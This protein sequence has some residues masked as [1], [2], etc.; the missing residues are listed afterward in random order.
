MKDTRLVEMRVFRAVAEAGG[1]TAAART[2]GVSQSFVSQTVSDLERRLGVAL[3]HRSTRAHRLTPE[4]ENYLAAAR[5]LL[6]AIDVAEGELRPDEPAGVLRV[7]A[8]RAFGADQVV[9]RMPEFLSRH[10]RVSLRLSLSDQMASLLEDGFDVAIRMGRLQDPS[11]ASRPLARLQR[12]VVAAPAY[13]ERHGTPA[14][15]QDLA[16][17]EGLLWEP[18][19]EH[20]NRWPF[21]SDGHA[22]EVTVRGRLHS[23]DGSALFQWCLAGAG[24]M[25]LA[26]HLALPAIRRGALVPLLQAHQAH[27]DLAIHAVFLPARQRV[28]RVRAF[29][30]F[31]AEAFRDPPWAR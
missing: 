6:D 22:Q 10:P 14:T 3:L 7:T 21:V 2:L 17:H 13:I 18:P 5:R 8:P 23:S 27:D 9:P 12:I 30:D 20:L 25:R 4:G 15:P 19:M 16:R 24:V 1:F 11:L 26:E 28:P 29:V 31:L